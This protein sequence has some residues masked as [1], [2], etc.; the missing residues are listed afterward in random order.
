MVFHHHHHLLLLHLLI[1]YIYKKYIEY[2]ILLYYYIGI[3]LYIKG[4]EKN[5]FVRNLFLQSKWFVG[6]SPP[7]RMVPP[8]VAFLP[9]CTSGRTVSVYSTGI[10]RVLYGKVYES[11]CNPRITVCVYSTGI[12]TIL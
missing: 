8:A 10:P 9:G 11:Y 4:A 3:I 1:Q 7:I 12:P 6:G 5:L 2:K